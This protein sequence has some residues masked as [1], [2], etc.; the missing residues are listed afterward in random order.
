MSRKGLLSNYFFTGWLI[1]HVSKTQFFCLTSSCRIPRYD[2]NL[3]KFERC[4][5]TNVLTFP[6][7]CCHRG[8]SSSSGINFC[9]L[10]WARTRLNSWEQQLRFLFIATRNLKKKLTWEINIHTFKWHLVF[11]VVNLKVSVSRFIQMREKPT[12]GLACLL[13]ALH[14]QMILKFYCMKKVIIVKIPKPQMSY[15]LRALTVGIALCLALCS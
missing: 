3:G 1:Y 10:C 6:C 2:C 8:Y 4:N 12:G 7:I 15:S 9:R 13:L 14:Y 11:F 5:A